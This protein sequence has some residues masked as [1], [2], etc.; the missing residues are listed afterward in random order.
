VFTLVFIV[1]LLF[2]LKE[3]IPKVIKMIKHR[4]EKARER[5]RIAALTKRESSGASKFEP[6][7]SS[8]APINKKEHFNKLKQL[9]EGDIK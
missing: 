4:V 9:V 3:I 2:T 6:I 1:D 8:S 7:I 5:K